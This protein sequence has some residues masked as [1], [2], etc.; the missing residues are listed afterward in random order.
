MYLTNTRSDIC[1]VVN[2]L[3][4]YLVYPKHVYLVVE[5]HVMRYLKGTLDY[6]LCYTRD[7]DFKIYGYTNSH[8]DG[9]SSEKKSTSRCCFILGLAMTSWKRRKKY[10]ISLSVEEVEY[11]AACF[12]SCEAIWLRKLLTGLF[13]LEME[14]IVI[15]CNN[16]SCLKMSEKP[17]F[18]DKSNHI[19]IQYFYICD[20]V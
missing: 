19:E 3:S 17:M 15:L 9:S 14:V 4:Q 6:G 1:F 18:H 8:W 16:Q 12:T 10:S 5:K 20:M 7:H 2:T 13:D 11:I